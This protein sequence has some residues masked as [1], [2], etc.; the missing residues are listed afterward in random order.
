MHTV[1]RY[2]PFIFQIHQS[3]Y[4]HSIVQNVNFRIIFAIDQMLN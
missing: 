1:P 4:H 3:F 2:L